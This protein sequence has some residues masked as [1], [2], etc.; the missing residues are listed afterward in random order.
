MF[1]SLSYSVA[2]YVLSS[3][4]CYV[5][6]VAHN[7]RY[8]KKSPSIRRGKKNILKEHDERVIRQAM[9]FRSGSTQVPKTK[10]NFHRRLMAE[11]I[12]LHFMRWN[13]YVSP[14]FVHFAF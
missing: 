7:H 3:G 5:F 8:E 1:I 11:K 14:F 6:N 9:P 13:F 10:E 12:F 4:G 2:L